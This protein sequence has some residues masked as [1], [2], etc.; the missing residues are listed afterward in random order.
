[1]R[2]TGSGVGVKVGV[3]VGEGKGE[4][5]AVQE[6]E[7]KAVGRVGVGWTTVQAATIQAARSRCS[8]RFDVI[9][10]LYW[11]IEWVSMLSWADV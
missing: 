2:T 10:S 7:G 6:G 8:A 5:V 4:G 9:D 11:K 3:G 1:M